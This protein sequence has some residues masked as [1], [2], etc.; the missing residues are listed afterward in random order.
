MLGK[1]IK[2]EFKA[3]AR[4]FLPAFALVLAFSFVGFFGQ[5][6]TSRFQDFS[7]PLYVLLFV[8]IIVAFFTLPT[9][10]NVWRF[11][12]NLL[13]S[14]GYLMFTLPVSTTSLIGAKLIVAT[15][16][17]VLSLV[18]GLAG[19]SLLALGSN[20][21]LT[22]IWGSIMGAD[23][24]VETILFTIV[25]AFGLFGST[26]MYYVSLAVGQL[27]NRHRVAA[28]IGAIIAIYCA[29][30][31]VAVVLMALTASSEQS[32]MWP[33]M[34]LMIIYNVVYFFVTRYVLTQKLNLV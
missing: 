4:W 31:I 12:R 32:N 3:T 23:P 21:S 34:V 30:H 16:W 5:S 11:H 25:I 14:E 8:G 19:T 28:T 22:S 24:S 2:Y 9:I 29:T 33:V 18:V 10:M 13:G 26:L 15:V 17:Q 1:L 7:V 27:S 6:M 20:G